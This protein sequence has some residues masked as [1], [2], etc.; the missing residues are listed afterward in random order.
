LRE[1]EREKELEKGEE[2]FGRR[3]LEEEEE[4]RDIRSKSESQT[5]I[6]LN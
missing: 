2:G 3:E 4:G 6:V 1:V 5:R